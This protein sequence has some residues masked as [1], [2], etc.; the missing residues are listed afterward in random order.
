MKLLVLLSFLLLGISPTKNKESIEISWND[1]IPGVE[2]EDPYLKLTKEQRSL[3]WD[4]AMAEIAAK[5]SPGT[6]TNPD[7]AIEKTLIK[8]LQKLEKTTEQYEEQTDMI[9]RELKKHRRKI[10]RQQESK[11]NLDNLESGQYRFLPDGQ[12][13]DQQLEVTASSSNKVPGESVQLAQRNVFGFSKTASKSWL[14]FCLKGQR[15]ISD[16]LFAF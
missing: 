6:Q 14:Y 3:I 11:L 5:N 12:E 8:R 2:A 10:W 7:A 13:L 16:L 4:V 1:L 9:R 15:P